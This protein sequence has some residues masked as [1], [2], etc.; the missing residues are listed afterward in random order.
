MTMAGD[1]YN[2]GTFPP[3]DDV[4]VWQRWAEVCKAGSKAPDPKLTDLD[5]GDKV[6]LSDITR[7][8]LTVVELGSLT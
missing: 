5:S 4:E 1:G 2:Y 8:G 3:E 6:R 7:R